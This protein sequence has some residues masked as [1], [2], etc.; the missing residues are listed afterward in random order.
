MFGPS[1]EQMVDMVERFSENG[2]Y[3]TT[4]TTGP[5]QMGGKVYINQG[6]NSDI[7][8]LLWFIII[9]NVIT[10]LVLLFHILVQ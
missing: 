4:K 8:P 1:H 9:L 3:K 5:V 2:Q 10:L 6:D 7:K